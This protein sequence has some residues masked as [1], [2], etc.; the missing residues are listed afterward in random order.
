MDANIV[1]P[2]SNDTKIALQT[3]VG[4]KSA[5]RPEGGR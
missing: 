2:P 4:P 1:L 3:G 5:V